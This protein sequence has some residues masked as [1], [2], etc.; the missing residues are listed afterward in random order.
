MHRRTTV[1]CSVSFRS[2]AYKAR[3]RRAQV[4]VEYAQNHLN[5]RHALVRTLTHEDLP[6]HDAERKHVFFSVYLRLPNTLGLFTQ[7]RRCLFKIYIQLKLRTPS[8]TQ[9]HSCQSVWIC[10][11]TRERPKSEILIEKSRSTSR[12]GL[13]MSRSRM[14]SSN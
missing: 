9:C 3:E 11:M 14:G 12:L 7:S 8:I 13:F 5:L 6:H 10:A 2:L 4:I 1:A